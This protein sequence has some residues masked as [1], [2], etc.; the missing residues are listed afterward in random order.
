MNEKL[1]DIEG[2]PSVTGART[3]P[4]AQSRWHQAVIH[5]QRRCPREVIEGDLGERVEENIRFKA[6]LSLPTVFSDER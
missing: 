5:R 4:F 3:G 1:W 2:A 6:A